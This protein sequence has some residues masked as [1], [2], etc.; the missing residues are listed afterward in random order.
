[1]HKPVVILVAGPASGSTLAL[2]L[3]K[4]GIQGLPSFLPLGDIE[5]ES[6]Q[7]ESFLDVMKFLT[8]DQGFG[9]RLKRIP[10]TCCLRVDVC[11]WCKI[12]MG[13]TK[14]TTYREAH[15][16]P[17]LFVCCGTHTKTLFDQHHEE[18]REPLKIF[19]C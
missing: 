14:K 3:F 10:D 16:H 13:S 5:L 4:T 6:N 12:Q 1:M 8:E 9:I 18:K 19:S 11:E 2:A 7:D 17:E 15:Q